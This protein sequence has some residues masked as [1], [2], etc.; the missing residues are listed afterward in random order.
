MVIE[1][2]WAESFMGRALKVDEGK[3]AAVAAT[4]LNCGLRLHARS[5]GRHPDL[6]WGNGPRAV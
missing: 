5:S 6:S 2:W 3:G 1:I 4:A